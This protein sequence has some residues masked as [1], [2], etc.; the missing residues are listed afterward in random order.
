MW[1]T[2]SI[3]VGQDFREDV[4]S[5]TIH[6]NGTFAVSIGVELVHKRP[7]PHVEQPDHVVDRRYAFPRCIGSGGQLIRHATQRPY[8]SNQEFP[9]P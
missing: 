4:E 8:P 6:K 9:Q 7:E 1:L 5:I 3:G 2:V